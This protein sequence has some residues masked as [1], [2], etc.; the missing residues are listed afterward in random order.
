MIAPTFPSRLSRPCASFTFSRASSITPPGIIFNASQIPERGDDDVI[1]VPQ[2]W[3]EVRDKV[4]RAESVCH[5]QQSPRLGI[6]GSSSI[7][8]RQEQA[9]RL[10]LE[11]F[12]F[13]D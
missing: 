2:D 10:H 5:Y 3:N 11:A 13:V 6:P 12:R 8:A 4:D 1:Q 9:K 7:F